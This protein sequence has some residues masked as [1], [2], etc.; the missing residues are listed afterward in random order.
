[1]CGILGK[2]NFKNHMA[3]D[4]CNFGEAL[5]LQEHRGPDDC[6]I[7]EGANFIFGHQRLS[8]IDLNSHAK[9]PMVSNCGKYTL[10]FNGEIYN[11]KEIKKDLVKRDISLILKV[12]PKS[13]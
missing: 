3:H 7:V 2:I 11:Y 9:Q 5:K 8:I 4:R 10:V 12:I 13:Y 1:M 6:D